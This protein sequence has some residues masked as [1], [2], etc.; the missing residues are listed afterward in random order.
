MLQEPDGWMREDLGCVGVVF[1]DKMLSQ[2]R[3]RQS[4]GGV[5]RAGGR[6]SPR[7][8]LL[9][10]DGRLCQR[11]GVALGDDPVSV[12]G[13]PEEFLREAGDGLPA[14]VGAGCGVDGG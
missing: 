7:Q 9:G 2:R 10:H 1:T 6:R 4:A 5:S 14:S 11:F 13:L 12:E 8:F 3:Q